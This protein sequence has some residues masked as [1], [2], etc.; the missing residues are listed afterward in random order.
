MKNFFAY[1]IFFALFAALMTGCSNSENEAASN[2]EL[3][4]QIMFNGSSTLASVIASIAADFSETY[5]TWDNVNSNFPNAP[6]S[7]HV[8][9]GGSGQGIRT[10]IDQTTDFGMLAREVRES[11]REQI[12]Y[13]QEYLIGIDALT[14]AI[15]PENPLASLKDGLTT[16][17]IVRI[18]SGE[19]ETWRDFAPSLPDEE[20]VVIIRD[21]GG[22]AHEVFQDNIMGDVDVRI[23]AIQA[24]S[25][26]ALVNRVIENRNAIG[27]ASFGVSNQHKDSLVLL[28]VDG[29]APSIE[30]IMNGSYIIQR[31]LLLVFSGE[32]DDIQSSFL[33]VILGEEGQR[34]IEDM[35]FIP[36]N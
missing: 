6:I 7:I 11:E 36:I 5:E 32:P 30:N 33:D 1:F 14:V 21:I 29:V 35:G 3:G 17:E 15:N 4:T 28:N 19:Y 12:S 27:Y 10:V 34:K 8:A 26:G 20:I 2:N 9:S 25:M 22:G 13:I 23:D 31:P 18:F 16:E 24:P